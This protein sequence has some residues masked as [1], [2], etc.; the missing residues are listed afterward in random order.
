MFI[1]Q[2]SGLQ[3]SV[4]SSVGGHDVADPAVVDADLGVDAGLVLLGA[5]C[6]PGHHA[7]QLAVAHHGAT[8]VHLV[9]HRE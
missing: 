8:G 1:G 7:L 6:P 2:R 5:A 3:V 4:L 9:G